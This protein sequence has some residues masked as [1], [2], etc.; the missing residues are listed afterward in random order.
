MSP[1]P[2]SPPTLRKLGVGTTDAGLT[3]WFRCPEHHDVSQEKLRA[4]IIPVSSSILLHVVR[5]S[6]S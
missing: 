2:D 4:V 3:A 6:L 1:V 5:S